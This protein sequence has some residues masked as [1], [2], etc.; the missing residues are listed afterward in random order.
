MVVLSAE[1]AGGT[2]L[3][4]TDGLFQL[5]TDP[6]PF[7]SWKVLRKQGVSWRAL[8]LTYVVGTLPFDRGWILSDI[9]AG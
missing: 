6:P 7:L 1:E 2:S 5:V 3:A 4:A 8:R 9:R